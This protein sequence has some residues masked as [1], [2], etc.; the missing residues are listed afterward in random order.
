MAIELPRELDD[1]DR[2]LA[3]LEDPAFAAH[4]AE[5]NPSLYLRVLAQR[6]KE[7]QKRTRWSAW[8]AGTAVVS[9]AAGMFASPFVM[10]LVA[11]AQAPRHTVATAPPRSAPAHHRAQAKPRALVIPPH[12]LPQHLVAAPIIAAPIV[13]APKPAIRRAL[14]PA[15]APKLQPKAEAAVERVSAPRAAHEVAAS[16][17]AAVS[18]AAPAGESQADR[19]LAMPDPVLPNGTKAAPPTSGLSG[20]GA[21]GAAPVLVGRDPCTPQ[22]GR[23]GSVLLGSI[24]R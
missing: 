24:A 23:I 16:A 2:R 1:L 3:S 21:G 6:D 12:A 10:K 18:A 15:V 17:P 22:G 13:A 7:A 4:L 19:L 20:H 8:L 9:L 11:P 5:E 14:A